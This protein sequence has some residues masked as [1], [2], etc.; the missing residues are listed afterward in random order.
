MLLAVMSIEKL[1]ALYFPLKAKSYS[2][3]GTAKWVTSILALIIAGLN[4]PMLIFYTFDGNLCVISKYSVLFLMM[5]TMLYSVV[6]ITLMLLA[7]T[8]I[9]YKL[10]YIKYKG[11]S[12]TNESVSKSSTRGSVMVVTVSLA[13]IILTSPRAVDSAIGL[14]ISNHPFGNVFAASMWYL[15]HSINGILYCVV[16]RKFRE[17]LLKVTPFRRNNTAHFNSTSIS[18][19]TDTSN[20][21]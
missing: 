17:E 11:I 7:N 10:M 4:F 13:F 9:I 3:V 14:V 6:P 12:H 1:F 19:T 5:D 16:G 2:T 18:V 8:A 21:V 20:A 15:N